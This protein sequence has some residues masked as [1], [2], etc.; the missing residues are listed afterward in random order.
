MEQLH[1]YL[2]NTE[3][4]TCEAAGSTADPLDRWPREAWTPSHPAPGNDVFSSSP[5]RMSPPSP[6]TAPAG[7]GVA[8]VA[9]CEQDSSNYC[10][11]LI[12]CLD[13][14]SFRL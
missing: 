12:N 14:S 3:D 6:P 10:F 4:L 9:V 11:L 2:L 1:I 13:V 5:Q 8:V 7:R